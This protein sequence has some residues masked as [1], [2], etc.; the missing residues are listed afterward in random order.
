MALARIS[1]AMTKSGFVE[2]KLHKTAWNTF[3]LTPVAS[4]KQIM[5]NSRG[6]STPCFAG[7]AAPLDATSIYRMS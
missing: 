2:N 5:P 4:T 6:L 3:G 7:T 1:L